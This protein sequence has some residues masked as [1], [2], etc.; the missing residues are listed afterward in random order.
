MQEE[1]RFILENNNYCDDEHIIKAI[2][3]YKTLYPDRYSS[4]LD[5]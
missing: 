1:I 5:D 4:L 3:L 2:V